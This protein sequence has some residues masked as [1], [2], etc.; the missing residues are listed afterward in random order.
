[1]VDVRHKIV[2]PRTKSTPRHISQL[3]PAPAPAP[4][5]STATATEG[6]APPPATE[7]A[8]TH[9]RLSVRVRSF[10]FMTEV[11]TRQFVTGAD[12][13]TLIA[14]LREYLMTARTFNDTCLM[15]EGACDMVSVNTL[16]DANIPM[17]ICGRNQTPLEEWLNRVA[18]AGPSFI[19]VVMG[20]S[21]HNAHQWFITCDVENPDTAVTVSVTR[22]FSDSKA[23]QYITEHTCDIRAALRYISSQYGQEIV[24]SDPTFP[25]RI[26]FTEGASAVSIV[27]TR[28]H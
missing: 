14:E 13:S 9:W 27:I 11:F 3:Y 24:V 23:P 1:M 17:P 21:H 12:W 10:D 25:I 4:A 18:E 5:E 8:V 26:E 22:T 15:N 7:P 19:D 28:T 2:M 6:H 20:S 16:A